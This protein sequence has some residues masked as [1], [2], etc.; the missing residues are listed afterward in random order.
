MASGIA[1]IARI[2]R[3]RFRACFGTGFFS[4]GSLVED[5]YPYFEHPERCPVWREPHHGVVVVS[6]W[7]DLGTVYRDTRTFSSV[8][9]PGREFS[10]E[11]CR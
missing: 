3:G 5:A 9:S 8:N 1:T 7:D 11:A 10:W 6:R 2:S 4:D